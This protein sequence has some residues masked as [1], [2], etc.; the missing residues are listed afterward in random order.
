ME[1]FVHVCNRD[2]GLK[3]CQFN[4][5]F[6]VKQCEKITLIPLIKRE[7]EVGSVIHSDECPACS[8][9]TAEGFRH[10]TV[11]YQENYVN[12]ITEASREY[13]ARDWI[14]INYGEKVRR[15]SACSP[16]SSRPLLLANEAAK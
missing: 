4:Q 15:S 16:K 7:C 2:V 11:N 9:L 3:D 1:P 13:K 6:I 8:Q 10:K 14:P 12:P 5:Y